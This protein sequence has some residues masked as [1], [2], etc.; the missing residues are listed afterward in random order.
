MS[1]PVKLGLVGCGRLAELGYVPAA[2]LSGE[3]RFVAFADPDPERRELLAGGEAAAFEDAERLLEAGGV[4]AL[5]IASP[6]TEHERAA[7]AAAAAGVPTLV[8]KPPAPDYA[9]AVRMSA[10]DPSPYVGF[11]RRFS[12]GR[13]LERTMPHGGTAQLVIHY[14]RFSWAPVAVRDPALID[15]APH[16]IDLAFGIGIGEVQGVSASSQRPE[17]VR[18]EVEGSRGTAL[19]DCAC[20][21][22]HRERVVV[23]NDRGTVVAKRASGGLV[24]GLSERLRG[25]PHPL[26]ASLAAQL[27]ELAFAARGGSPATL[28]TADEAAE[29]MRVV[30]L[31]AASLARGGERVAGAEEV[32]R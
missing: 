21:R 16:L 10:L 3:V 27:G 17:R 13:G 28:A 25:G 6:P 5:V 29:V 1:E 23:R 4:D 7:I 18:I 32:T 9:G 8:E 12:L 24:R 20:D 14:R 30:A 31:A 26:V 11:N 2:K 22:L 19:I 15:L